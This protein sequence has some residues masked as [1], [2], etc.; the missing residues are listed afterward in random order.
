MAPAQTRI[1]PSV[2]IKTLHGFSVEL[3][4]GWN[5]FIF[6]SQHDDTLF[7]RSLS[8]SARSYGPS[9]AMYRKEWG[10]TRPHSCRLEPISAVQGREWWRGCSCHGNA[11]GGAPWIATSLFCYWRS[12][13]KVRLLP[14]PPVTTDSTVSSC[15]SGQLL[16]NGCRGSA[17]NENLLNASW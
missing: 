10:G 7:A 3:T 13:G 5:A 12:R 16:Q 15:C 9:P 2:G 14:S 6:I 11:G 1:L 17:A 8:K 4:A